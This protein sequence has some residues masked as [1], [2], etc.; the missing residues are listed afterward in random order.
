MLG[1]EGLALGIYWGY[2]GAMEKK[3]ETWKLLFRV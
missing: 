2:L 3:M 1:S